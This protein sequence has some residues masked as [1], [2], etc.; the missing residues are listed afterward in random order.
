MNSLP[1]KIT[2][3]ISTSLPLTSTPPF[4]SNI[5]RALFNL[6]SFPLPTT[7]EEMGIEKMIQE[8]GEEGERMARS[9]RGRN[10]FELL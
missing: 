1:F 3:E 10:M 2:P 9:W 6:A 5:H 4:P 7:R 8:M